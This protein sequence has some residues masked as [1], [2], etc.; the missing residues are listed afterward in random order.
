MLAIRSA[1]A[2]VQGGGGRMK[3]ILSIAKDDVWFVVNNHIAEESVSVRTEYAAFKE[4]ERMLSTMQW[5]LQK[6]KFEEKG[7]V[8]E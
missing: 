2:Q 8:A 3:Y 6:K 1:M 7:E 4:V 5:E